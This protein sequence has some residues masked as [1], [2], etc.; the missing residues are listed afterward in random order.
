MHSGD[1]IETPADPL[2]DI[3]ESAEVGYSATLGLL[4]LP[5]IKF[6]TIYIQL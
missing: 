3:D 4:N 2:Q 1:G 5:N 6:K